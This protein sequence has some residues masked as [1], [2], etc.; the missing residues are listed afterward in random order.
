MHVINILNN[1]YK[2][3]KMHQYT[4]S[5]HAQKISSLDAEHFRKNFD[6]TRRLIS[7]FN[8]KCTFQRKCNMFEIR[9][10]APRVVSNGKGGDG[11]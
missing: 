2:F 3:K 8:E 7:G 9:E 4:H 10:Y 11:V 5:I 6:D 1:K